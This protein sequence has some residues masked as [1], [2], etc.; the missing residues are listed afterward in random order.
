MSDEPSNEEL[1]TVDPDEG[2]PEVLGDGLD[3]DLREEGFDDGADEV[4]TGKPGDLAFKASR[5]FFPLLDDD[6]LAEGS[7]EPSNDD[8]LDADDRELEEDD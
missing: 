1:E 6:E 3:D 4:A 2:C 5:S 7:D 8:E